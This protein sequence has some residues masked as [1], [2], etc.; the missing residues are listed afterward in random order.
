MTVAVTHPRRGFARSLLPAATLLALAGCTAVPGSSPTA[1]LTATEGAA[2]T[3]LAAADVAPA[4][5]QVWLTRLEWAAAALH[6]TDLAPLDD[7]WDGRLVVE[8]P[9]TAGQYAALAGADG[10]D[11]AA[12]THCPAEGARITINPVVYDHDAEYLDS[13][14]LHEGVH[15]ATGSSCGGE[16]AQWIEEGLAEWV[17]GEHSPASLAANQAW[18]EAYLVR[19]G[20]PDELPP[21]ADFTGDPD[22][23]SA[24]Y[25]LARQ[26]VA[27]AVDQ[28]GYDVAMEFFAADFAGA[29]DQA[30]TAQVTQWYLAGLRQLSG[31]A[32]R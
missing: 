30:A 2:V 14:V 15:V 8:L 20:I 11:A 5:R 16:A 25:G 12:V 10:R 1:S 17:T 32:R 4:Q 13:L 24:A 29:P 23:V 6:A 9:A 31:S 27:V 21:D 3:V 26:A 7:G 28:L 22:Q 19:H 18:V